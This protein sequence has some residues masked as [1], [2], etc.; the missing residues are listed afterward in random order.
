ME[1]CN[2]KGNTNL[3]KKAKRDNQYLSFA[4]FSFKDKGKIGLVTV[5]KNLII[6]TIGP[7]YPLPQ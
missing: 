1:L 7:P 2:W 6:S 3:F 4:S 5:Q